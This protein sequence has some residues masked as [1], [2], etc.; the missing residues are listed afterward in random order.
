MSESRLAHNQSLNAEL[1]NTDETDAGKAGLMVHKLPSFPSIPIIAPNSLEAGLIKAFVMG[2]TIYYA[3][4][5][6]MTS[7]AASTVLADP[8]ALDS[9]EAHIQGQT[10]NSISFWALPI[11]ASF[12]FMSLGLGVTRQAKFTCWQWMYWR[13][14][15]GGTV[16]QFRTFEGNPWLHFI[17]TR[18]GL[19]FWCTRC[20]VR[21]SGFRIVRTPNPLIMCL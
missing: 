12:P 3:K 21:T 6:T 17:F 14:L 13:L 19:A 4:V 5:Y 7:V 11:V 9:I 10:Q 18:D 2:I 20:L 15:E 8:N 1:L 16:L